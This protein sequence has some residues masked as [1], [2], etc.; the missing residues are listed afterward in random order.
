M[1]ITIGT[2]HLPTDKI[3]E[4]AL[5]C[6][7]ASTY[8]LYQ[9]ERLSLYNAEWENPDLLESC[10]V[11]L[12]K[13]VE[14]PVL[15]FYCMDEDI[16]RLR[17]WEKGE[18]KAQCGCSLF[19]DFS[20]EE[21]KLLPFRQP[22]RLRIRKAVRCPLCLQRR[23]K[24]N[25]GT[26]W[27]NCLRIFPCHWYRIQ[28]FFYLWKRNPKTINRKRHKKAEPQLCFLC[29]TVFRPFRRWRFLRA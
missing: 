2:L 9:Q 27:R 12:S 3:Q 16:F 23:M 29:E 1:A 11:A 4:E 24:T 14:V 19:D 13:A 21:K 8:P 17:L 15:E 26:I 10:G 25:T 18:P 28:I 7:P 6:L 22:L 20:I 5:K